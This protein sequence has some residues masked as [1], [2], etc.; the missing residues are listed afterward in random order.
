M[1]LLG[2]FIWWERRCADPILEVSF[3]ADARFT[4]ASVAVTLVFF[5]MF[6]ALFFV[7]QYLQFVLGYRP[8]RSGVA[9]L[10]VAGVLMVAAPTSAKL[11]GSVRHQGG[12]GPAGLTLVATALLLFSGISADSGYGYIAVVLCVIGVGMGFAMAPATDSIMGSLPPDKA[13]VGSAMNDTTREIGGAL[14]VAV[15]GSVTTALYGDRFA[16]SGAYEQLHKAN[17]VAAAA[18]RESVGA[19]AVVAGKLPAATAHAVGRAANVAFV[20]ALAVSV[21]VA[22]VVALAGAVVAAVFLPARPQ[23]A[24]GPELTTLIDGAAQRLDTPVRRNLAAATLGLLA[25]AGMSSITY[26]GVAARSGVAT[27]TLARYWTSRVDA[28]TDALSEVFADHPIPDTGD[29]H[30]DLRAYLLDMGEVVFLADR[31][32]GDRRADRRGVA[33]SR[34]RGGIPG[35]G[36]RSAARRAGGPADHGAGPADHGRRGCGRQAHRAGLLPRTAR[37]R[38]RRGTV[39]GVGS[40]AVASAC[41][42]TR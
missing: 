13:G 33:Q 20:H 12:G 5:A 9:L 6:G 32:P 27:T 17:A 7:S 15:M 21:I 14:G 36:H 2:T 25:D 23:I 1:V 31:T 11:C 26:N 42:H 29:L 16:S 4:A 18:A 39:R 22:A 37:R 8:L 28:V 40:T 35:A 34:T 30:S 19:A 10:P 38:G 24:G 3:F 41:C